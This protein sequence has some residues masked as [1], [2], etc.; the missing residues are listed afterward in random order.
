MNDPEVSPAAPDEL[1]GQISSLQRQMT[2]LLIAL[3]VISCT[4]TA[5]LFY[6]S[7]ILGRDLENTRPQAMQMIQNY[8]QKVPQMKKLIEDFTAYGKTHPDFQPILKNFGLIPATTN[9]APTNAAPRK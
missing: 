3:F 9:A 2:L 5:F 8:N 6:Q 4:L 1:A 7:R